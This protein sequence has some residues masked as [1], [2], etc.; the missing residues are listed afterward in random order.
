MVRQ[1]RA[2]GI[3]VMAAL[4]GT[5]PILSL[6]GPPASEHQT[7]SDNLLHNPGFEGSYVVGL[8]HVNDGVYRDN[9]FT[10]EGWVTWWR[11]GMGDGGEF[12]QPEVQVIAADHPN[13]GY[14]A[15]L[16]R[17]YSG[18]QGLKV[19]NMWRPQDAGIY[20]CVWGLQPGATVELTAYAHAWTCNN[21][22]SLLRKR[23][24]T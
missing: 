11:Q 10:P 6:A 21:A 15:E 14:D 1:R 3:L 13:Y 8:V 9:I 22:I 24:H 12:G 18:F 7:G 16:P 5:V 17:I 20:Q 2:A 19:F 4:V 23:V